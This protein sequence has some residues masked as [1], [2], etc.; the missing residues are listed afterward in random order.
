[1]GGQAL[2]GEIARP[3]L[4]VDDHK[5]GHVTDTILLSA[6]FRECNVVSSSAAVWGASQ[7]HISHQTTSYQVED[8]HPGVSPMTLYLS[9]GLD[10]VACPIAHCGRHASPATRRH[11]IPCHMGEGRPIDIA[12]PQ[13][14]YSHVDQPHLCVPEPTAGIAAAS[15]CLIRVSQNPLQERSSSPPTPPPP[16]HVPEPL[17][18]PQLPLSYSSQL[19]LVSAQVPIVQ[20]DSSGKI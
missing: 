17:Q 2:S 20:C 8:S 1:M 15:P 12:H 19:F 7:S 6:T 3:E 4:H 9:D 11:G 5:K 13:M 10:L 18:E 14:L 16:P